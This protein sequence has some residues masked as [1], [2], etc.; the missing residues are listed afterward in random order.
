MYC[1]QSVT[2]WS[3]TAQSYLLQCFEVLEHSWISQCNG[4]VIPNISPMD[5]IPFK[6]I[7]IHQ[8]VNETQI[9][10]CSVLE[11]VEHCGGEPEQAANMH[12]N[13]LRFTLK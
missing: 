1:T 10:V 13:R 4:F 2:A 6:T 8:E 12:M 5:L 9:H 7:I 11:N 3:C